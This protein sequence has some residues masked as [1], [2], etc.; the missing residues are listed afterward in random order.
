MKARYIMTDGNKTLENKLSFKPKEAFELCGLGTTK[1]YEALRTKQ[2]RSIKNGRN[3]IIPRAA[4]LEFLNG[5]S[6]KE[7]V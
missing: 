7:V 6:Q 4:I 2:L 5:D 1:G 3:Y